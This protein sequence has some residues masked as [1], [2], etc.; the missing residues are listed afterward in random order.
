MF[1]QYAFINFL[2]S[3]TVIFLFIKNYETWTKPDPGPIVKEESKRSESPG[4]FIPLLSTSSRPKFDASSLPTIAEKNIFHP[5][6]REFVSLS[7]EQPKAMPVNRPQIQ[8]QGILITDE[9]QRASLTLQGKS[10]AKGEKATKTLNLGDQIGE[11]KLTKILPDRIVLETPGDTYE[12]FLYD[13]KSPKKRMEIRT[14]TFPTESIRS[15][16]GEPVS[17]TRT[18]PPSPQTL[19]PSIGPTRE[20]QPPA[21]QP[22]ASQVTPA[23]PSSLLPSLRRPPLPEEITGGKK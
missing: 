12:V 8:L 18:P 4:E 21:Y 13:L 16:T 14:P 23:L 6:R 19:Q 17:T 5:E 10:L 3:I 2:L 9:V 11:Y 7:P 15:S 20:I 22:P 1:K